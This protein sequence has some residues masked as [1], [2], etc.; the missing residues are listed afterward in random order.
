M[1]FYFID[2]RLCPFF[3]SSFLF[4]FSSVGSVCCYSTSSDLSGGFRFRFTDWFMLDS[5]LAGTSDSISL[6]VCRRVTS[7]N[8]FADL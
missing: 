3:S 8:S 2:D 5:S 6:S 4:S 1:G 7:N